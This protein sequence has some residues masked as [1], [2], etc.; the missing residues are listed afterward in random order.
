M[1]DMLP[2]Q[3]DFYGEGMV[4]K[5][6]QIPSFAPTQTDRDWMGCTFSGD[7]H[8]I[9]AASIPA[10]TPDISPYEEILNIIASQWATAESNIHQKD[11][12]ISPPRKISSASLRKIA[13]LH[14]PISGNEYSFQN[15]K[16]HVYIFLGA[17]DD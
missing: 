3:F 16:I 8:G 6:G 11:M 14:P 12:M 9:I 2:I 17:Q 7:S 15:Q 5:S 10:D 13:S 1:N 4:Q